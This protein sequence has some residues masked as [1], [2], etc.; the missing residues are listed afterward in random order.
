ME[1][2]GEDQDQRRVEW[3]ID[4]AAVTVIVEQGARGWLDV[5]VT[6]YV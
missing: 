2:H 6:R 5:D 3:Q 1:R 4:M